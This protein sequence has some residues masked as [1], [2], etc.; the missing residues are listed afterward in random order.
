MAGDVP[1]EVQQMIEA[2]RRMAKRLGVEF[3]VSQTKVEQFSAYFASRAA[4]RSQ[5]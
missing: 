4:L 3:I 2:S 5:P 1:T